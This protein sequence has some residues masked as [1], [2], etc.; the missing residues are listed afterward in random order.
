[1]SMK[2]GTICTYCGKVEFAANAGASAVPSRVMFVVKLVAIYMMVYA[3]PAAQKPKRSGQ[4]HSIRKQ[5]NRC[6]RR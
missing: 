6:A 4:K 2:N 5:S 1:M 3:H